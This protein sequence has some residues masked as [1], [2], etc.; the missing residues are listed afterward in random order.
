ML[1]IKWMA[2]TAD[3]QYVINGLGW[4]TRVNK[5][6]SPWVDGIFTQPG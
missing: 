1:T 4:E 3:G 5:C 6:A 2:G